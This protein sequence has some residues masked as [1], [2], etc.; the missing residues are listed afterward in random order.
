VDELLASWENRISQQATVF[1]KF[2]SDVVS[3]DKQLIQSARRLKELSDEHNVLKQKSQ[4]IDA[5]IKSVNDH[6]DALGKL[7]SHIQE[8]LS[9]DRAAH[10][11]QYALSG[12]GSSS[13]RA[14][15]VWSQLCDIE[16]EVNAII[17][18]VERIG[19]P[20]EGNLSSLTKLIKLHAHSISSLQQQTAQIRKV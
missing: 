15:A 6:Q 5:A 9:R 8:E 10:A 1:Q 2:A 11:S 17:K 7:L 13:E 4:H 16:N 18:D 19:A 14:A 3:V 20:E 12:S